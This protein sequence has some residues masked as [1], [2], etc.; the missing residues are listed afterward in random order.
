MLESIIIT[1]NNM[2][3]TISTNQNLN[4]IWWIIYFSG[5]GFFIVRFFIQLFRLATLIFKVGY[6]RKENL[7]IIRTTKAYS[8]FSFFSFIFIGDNISDIPQL[9][10][11]IAHE[12]V[13]IQQKHSF[14]L[15]LLEF[16]TI[17]QWF[18]PFAWLYKH[19]VK[20]LH[21]YLADQGV[22]SNGYDKKG[23]QQMLLNQTFGVQFN[24]LTNNFNHSLIKRR[25]IMMSKS[26]SNQLAFLKMGLVLPLAIIISVVFSFTFSAKVIAQEQ[27]KESP[28]T[29][30]NKTIKSDEQKNQVF[31]V[32]EK[33]P[34][35][36]G[37]EEA[38]IKYFTENLKYPPEARQKGV[39]GK[40]FVTYVIEED[41][42]ISNVKVLRGIGGGCDEEAV[43]VIS[44]MPKWNPGMQ[45]GKAVRVQFNLPVNFVLDD[46]KN[47]EKSGEDTKEL[48]PPP[49]PEKK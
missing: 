23:Y 36:P 6:I 49:L 28:V 1:P 20:C 44:M 45:R 42:S 14:D 34:S 26:K 37:G 9:D 3:E 12:R 41:G 10:K 39:T 18:N 8:P 25:L 21:E 11:I 48:T 31:T 46:G 19:K 4:Q 40:V 30:E 2:A 35:Y 16:L 33:M 43:R 29:N 5:T 15:I 47:K 38:R 13:H 24:Y 32:V 22:L 7:K 27:K 17:I